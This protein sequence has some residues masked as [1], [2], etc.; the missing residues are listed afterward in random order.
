MDVQLT[1]RDTESGPR[2]AVEFAGHRMDLIPGSKNDLLQAIEAEPAIRE[3][4]ALWIRQMMA[5]EDADR[6]QGDA[7]PGDDVPRYTLPGS[8]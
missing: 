5:G 7:S 6:R 4:K 8:G 3:Q 1:R 2:L